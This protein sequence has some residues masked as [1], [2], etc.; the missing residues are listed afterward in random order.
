MRFIILIY[1]ILIMLPGQ[2]RAETLK[3]GLLHFPP[4]CIQDKTDPDKP[5]GTMVRELKRT[6]DLAGI[7]YTIRVYPPKRLFK[8][9][10]KGSIDF[11]LAGPVQKNRFKLTA[12][13][14]HETIQTMNIRA[15][16]AHPTI[17][18]PQNKEDFRDKRVAVINGYSYAG[19][20]DDLRNPDNRTTIYSVNSHKS[21]LLMLLSNRSD[22]FLDY[23]EPI[24]NILNKIGRRR[25]RFSNLLN[26]KIY[27]A[28]SKQYP[29]HESVL[30]SIIHHYHEQK[31]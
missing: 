14:S 5:S 4:F 10:E 31:I 23:K 15:Y 1:L 22:F 17:K 8:L 25:F 27:F 18:L 24:E 30:K 2:G 9:F 28:I 29:N 11:I 12:V 19:F 13:F 6:F 7:E 16:T 3:V 20:L 21:G 26:I